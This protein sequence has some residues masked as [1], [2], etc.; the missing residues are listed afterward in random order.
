LY[1]MADSKIVSVYIDTAALGAVGATTVVSNTLI[2]FINGFTQGFGILIANSFG[3]K[4]FKR[5]RKFIAGSVVLTVILTVVISFLGENYIENILQVLKTPNDI[6][7]MAVSYVKIILAG[8]AFTAIYNLSANTLR[9]VGDSKR[10]LYCLM[11]A[12]LLNIILDVLFVGYFRWG[13]EGAAYATILSQAVSAILCFGCIVIKYKDII[14]K[15]DEW[16]LD[17]GQYNNLFS[18]GLAMGLMG[19]I[20]NIGTVVLQSSINSLGTNIVVA[21][22]LARRLFDM[23]C[24]ATFT[25][26]NAMTTY[27]SQNMGAGKYQRVRQGVKHAV[28]IASS[29]TVVLIILCYTVARYGLIWLGSTTNPDIIDPAVMYLRIG[30]VMFFFLGP[31]FVFRCTLQGMGQKI[32]PV[33]SSILEMVIKIVSAKFFVPIFGYLGVALTEPT[34]WVIMLAMLVF[35]YYRVRPTGPDCDTVDVIME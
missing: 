10:P 14:P 26:G 35:T 29:E 12:V 6:L 27:I 2:G 3:A 22:T 17:E 7:P 11:I 30:I 32:V 31:L 4:D 34:S 5:M 25:L 16:K 18:S 9:A 23:F 24:V 28:I 1:N 20:V 15:K 33:L 8:T 13:I 21:H 19:G